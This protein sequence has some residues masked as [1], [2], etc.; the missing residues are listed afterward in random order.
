[1]AFQYSTYYSYKFQFPNPGDFSSDY[2]NLVLRLSY[3]PKQK[4]AELNLSDSEEAQRQLVL[5]KKERQEK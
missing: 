2:I 1:M 5:W 3:L 4:V